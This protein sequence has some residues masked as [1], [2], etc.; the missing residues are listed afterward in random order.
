MRIYVCWDNKA[1]HPIIGEHP[2]G[3]AYEAVVDAGYE[4]EVVKAYGW[5]KLPQA[6]NFTSGRKEVRELT[7]KDEVPVLVLDDGA[8]VAGTAEIVAWAKA[9]PA[10]PA[11]G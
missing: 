3:V 8:V 11:A 2:C 7:G 10:A 4:P 6:L 9:N 1:K 5:A